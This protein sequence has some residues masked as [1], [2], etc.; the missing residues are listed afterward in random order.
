MFRNVQNTKAAVLA[1]AILASFALQ[2]H[3]AQAAKTE[4]PALHL[5]QGSHP[6]C[7]GV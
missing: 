5:G 3:E 4:T 1:L 7:H 2:S 6:P